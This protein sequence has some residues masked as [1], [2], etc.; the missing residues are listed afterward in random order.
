MTEKDLR[1][2]S[3]A[4]LLEM[5]IAQSQELAELR[6]RLETAEAALIRR[7]IDIDTAG[8]IAEASLK[9]NG[10]FEAA[11]AAS[12]QYMENIRLLSERQE[13]VCRRMEW[14]TQE[15]TERRIAETEKLCAAM[16]ADAK[17]TCSEMIQK[18]KAESQAY[19]DAVSG[20]L[21][22]FYAEHSQLRELLFMTLPNKDRR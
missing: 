11:Q 22:S 13:A 15:K 8:S 21:D 20:K 3:R 7:E 4:D 14:E 10:V 17:I 1:K 19:W 9:L 2:L 18:A 6:S 16:E 5:L 12:E